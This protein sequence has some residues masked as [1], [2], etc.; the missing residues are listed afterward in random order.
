MRFISDDNPQAALDLDDDIVASTRQLI[1][2]PKI[3]HL[4]SIPD[5]REYRVRRNYRLI[6]RI[7]G[8]DLV[9]LAVVHAARNWPES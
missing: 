2:F 3:G 5:T 9:I 4:G 1:D 7:I 8:E 6:Y